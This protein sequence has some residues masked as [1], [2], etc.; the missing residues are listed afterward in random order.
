MVSSPGTWKD[1][2]QEP[3]L[4]AFFHFYLSDRA[5]SLDGAVDFQDGGGGVALRKA[6]IDFL[7]FSILKPETSLF[8][9]FL[10]AS[11]EDDPAGFSVQAVH[12]KDGGEVLLDPF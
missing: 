3:F 8:M 5:C 11:K 9:I 7:D 10:G 4:I 2:G 12:D 1:L 6:M